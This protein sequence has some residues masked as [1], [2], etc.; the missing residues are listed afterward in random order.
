MTRTLEEIKRLRNR[1]HLTQKE[2]ADRAGVSQSLIAKIESNK[3]DPTFTKAQ[4]IF[5][6]LE[7]LREKEETKARDVMHKK[8]SFMKIGDPLKDIIKVMKAK[9][10]SQI[11]ILSREKVCGL[12]TEGIILKRIAETP[13]RFNSLKAGDVME[14]VPPIVSPKTGLKTLLN[15]LQDFQVVLVSEKGEMKG[16][17][18]KSDLLGNI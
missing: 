7:Q 15:L 14:D 13:E 18:S 8:I 4:L 2:L 5:D 12:V 6:A 16:I 10:I 1:Y 9:G 11:P 3:L 17:I